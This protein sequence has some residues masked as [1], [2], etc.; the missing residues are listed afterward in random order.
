VRFTPGSELTVFSIPDKF[1]FSAAICLEDIFPDLA[2][3]LARTGSEAII[4]QVDTESFRGTAQ[5]LQHLRRARLTA[6]SAAIPMVRA[7][8]SGVS[9][10]IDSRGR[11]LRVLPAQVPAS[12]TLPLRVAPDW[13]PYRWTGDWPWLILLGVVLAVFLGFRRTAACP[14]T[15]LV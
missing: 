14:P 7:A 13:S 3:D 10:S 4:A 9:C 2:R 6:V 5:P 11:V 12:G 8:N 1:S 15:R